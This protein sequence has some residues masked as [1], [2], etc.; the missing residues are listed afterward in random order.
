MACEDNLCHCSLVRG[1][2]GSP[3]RVVDFFLGVKLE[4]GIPEYRRVCRQDTHSQ[5]TIVQYSLITARTAQSMRLAQEKRD[6]HC[7]FV[8]PKRC[9][10]LVC[11]MSHPWLFS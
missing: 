11:H 1:F 2:F 4:E 8:R 3:S 9:C 10:H 5:G 6:L 7:I